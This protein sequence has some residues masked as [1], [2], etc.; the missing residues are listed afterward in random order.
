L[1]ASS[2]GLIFAEI[3]YVY[4]D[5]TVYPALNENPN[6]GS[7]SVGYLTTI[8]A[9][10]P[11]TSLSPFLTDTEMTGL[12][13]ASSSANCVLLLNL[14]TTV[15]PLATTAKLVAEILLSIVLKSSS[16]SVL[17]TCL[18]SAGTLTFFS[19]VSNVVWNELPSKIP[20]G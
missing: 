15:I 5:F 7:A 19:N 16:L 10:S 20:T 1:Y 17:N 18:F 2:V 4:S 12:P 8:F 3:A 9:A 13:L 6:V 11:A 14:S